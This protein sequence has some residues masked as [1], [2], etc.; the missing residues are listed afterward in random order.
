MTAVGFGLR[1]TYVLARCEGSTHDATVL[2]DAIECPNS[3]RVPESSVITKFLS[4]KTT[5][6]SYQVLN[7]ILCQ[8]FEKYT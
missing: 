1:F 3:L 8:K 4:I 5:R 7:T 2:R 6:S